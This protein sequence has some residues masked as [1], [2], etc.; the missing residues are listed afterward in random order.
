MAM[1]FPATPTNGQVYTVGAVSY[2]WNGYGWVLSAGDSTSFVKKA[3]DT[4]T[5]DLTINKVQPLVILDKTADGNAEII[6]RKNGKGRWG[7]RLGNA[8][9]ESTGN[10]G[11]DFE[12]IRADDA[13][14]GIPGLAP[15]T[16]NRATGAIAF[17]TNAV[18]AGTS[19][20]LYLDRTG[21]GGTRELIGRNNAGLA[22]WA[23]S[24]GNG[25]AE[26]GGNKGSD[27]TIV[28][29]GDNGSVID[30]PLLIARDTGDVGISNNVSINKNLTVGAGAGTGRLSL[31]NGGKLIEW[32]GS[33]FYANST[34]YTQ[35]DLRSLGGSLYVNAGSPGANSH[36]WYCNEVGGNAVV[37]YYSPASNAYIINFP[38]Q[39]KPN[40]TYQLNGPIQLSD[41]FAS[42]NGQNGSYQSSVMNFHYNAAVYG[43]VDSTNMGTIYFTSDYRIKK[44]VVELGS[45]WD[46]VKALRPIK[47]THKDWTP[48]WEVENREKVAA[49]TKEAVTPFMAGDDVERWGFVAHELQETLVP[50]AS[51]GTKDAEGLI[52]SPNPWTIIAALTKT[53][54]EMQA[55]I[56]ALEGSA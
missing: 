40:F 46:T 54:Q 23:L 8:T 36:L 28:R 35:G 29:A 20:C 2:T 24:L 14:T 1:D 41:G 10:V 27:F 47:Y 48:P 52:Q 43:F 13:G 49:D 26:S 16:I 9:A 3:G 21:A 22:R 31:G 18:I 34:L 42:R 30:I 25:T 39:V 50:S 37:S 55:R 7:V 32:N 56:E 45:M 6:G 5:G 11:S 17:T 44:D 19:P 53:I 4:M 51:T 38:G 12:I 15:L 33:Y